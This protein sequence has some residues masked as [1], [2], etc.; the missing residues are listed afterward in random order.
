MK[1]TP[2]QLAGA[3]LSVALGAGALM[4]FSVADAAPGQIAGTVFEDYNQNGVKDANEPGLAG[5]T[6]TVTAAGGGN[7]QT[8]VSATDGTYALGALVGKQ[9]V[10]F[11]NPPT[12]LFPS[13][14]GSDNGSTVQFAVA[15]DTVNAA[16]AAPSDYCQANPSFIT[17]CMF[18]GDTALATG[19]SSLKTAPWGGGAAT[20]VNSLTDT[21]T[22]LG[23]AVQSPKKVYT[24]AFVKRHAGLGT[25]GA[26]GIYLTDPTTGVTQSFVDVSTLGIPVGSVPDTATRGLGAAGTPNIDAAV[27]PLVGKAGLGDID[28]SEDGQSLW[29][30]SLAGR[31]LHR[32]D[33]PANGSA[34]TT[35]NVLNAGVI[36]TTC[37]NGVARPFGLQPYR[38]KIYVGVVCTGEN[39]GSTADLSASVIVYDEAAATWSTKYGPFKID[40]T[41]GCSAGGPCNWQPWESAYSD[42]KFLFGP[43]WGGISYPQPMLSD[44]EFDT[45]GSLVLGFRDRS[46]DQFGFGQI[47]P[48]GT[49]NE[50]AR[51][52]GDI[53]RVC[54]VSGAL[55]LEG[56]VGCASNAV[57]GQGPGGGEFYPNEKNTQYGHQETSLGM[58]ELLKTQPSVAV[59]AYD[60]TTLYEGGVAFYDKTSGATTGVVSYYT[61]NGVDSSPATF[62]KTNGLGDLEALCDQAPIE[63]GNRLWV[64]NNGDGIQDAA[65]AG[66]G[67]VTVEL[68]KAGVLV[69]T[70]T[71]APDGSYYFNAANVTLGGATGIVANM[72]YEIRIPN[73]AGATKQAALAG[74]SLTVANAT[75]T[76]DEIDS[77]ATLSTTTPTTAI[78]PVPAVSIPLPGHNNHSF[79]AGYVPAYSVGN[80]VW[81]DNGAGAGGVANDGLQNGTE[82]GVAGVVVKLFASDASGNPTGVALSSQTTDANGFYRFDNLAPG[83]YVIVVDKNGSPTL[84][85]LNSSTGVAPATDVTDRNDNGIDTPLAAGSVLPGGIA[86]G[87]ITLGPSMPLGETD[88]PIGGAPD[89]ATDD[90]SNQT[91]DFGFA[92]TYSLGNRVWF[93]TN[94]NG[95]SDATEVGIANVKVTLLDASGNPVSGKTATTDA[96]G[97][98][99]FDGLAAG[100]YK[101]RID[102]MNFTTGGAL[103]GAASS[104]PTALNPNT[105]IDSDDNGLQPA[106][107]VAPQTSG[108][109]SGIVSLNATTA[110]PTNETDVASPNPAGEAANDRSNLTVDFGFFRTTVGNTVWYD[111]NNDGK[112]DASEPKLA[113]V[114]VEL[115]DATTGAVIGRATTDSNGLYEVTAAL[116]GSPLPVGTSVKVSIAAGQTVLAGLDAS[117]VVGTTD[118]TNHGSAMPNGDVMSVPFTLTPGVTTGGQTVDNAKGTTSNPTLDFGFNAPLASLGD[119]VW[120]DTNNNGIQDAGELGVPNVTV[121]LRDAAGV[122]LKT[123][124][125]DPNGN[126]KFI[127]LQPGTYVVRFVPSTLPAGATFTA[128]NQGTNDSVNSDADSN[129][130]ITKGYTIGKREYLPTVDAGIV[131]A[132]VPPVDPPFVVPP[133]VTPIVTLP[134]TTLP[135]TTASTTLPVTSVAATTVAPKTSTP[136]AP[137]ATTKG[138]IASTVWVDAN[139]NGTIDKGEKRVPNAEI[140]ITGPNGYTKTVVTDANGYYEV[141]D[142]EPGDYTVQLTGVGLSPDLEYLRGSVVTVTVLGNSVAKVEFP[143]AV[144]NSL[145]YT[146]S[147]NTMLFRIAMMLLA[148]GIGALSL[149]RRRRSN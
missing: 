91:I 25:L 73:S 15:G 88:L 100:D 48:T 58:T 77:D 20:S 131:L 17:A 126:Y 68:Y 120:A 107:A 71:T 110:E 59:S 30:V 98:Y 38:G 99:R 90:H 116:D 51:S 105:D 145:A 67:S 34:P 87:K 42:A 109:V 140:V 93:D 7:V 85:G 32:I 137:A 114:V 28:M 82:P 53:L 69:G 78:I 43:S 138:G 19:R 33:L 46:G 83:M 60:V 89:S 129:S 146:G 65:D 29:V 8:T 127:D 121:E 18:G 148:V 81:I 84:N 128:Q 132:V 36:P 94:N 13:A 5:V 26:G 76:A 75:T 70:T 118:S 23:V 79:D 142:L 37:A 134:S 147:N 1:R 27:W 10:E 31:S 11:T 44:I 113:G 72:D 112:I 136:A 80:R 106:T 139:K 123:T 144:G 57:N 103:F 22:V 104:T 56:G 117:A 141:G 35:S 2:L 119:T 4:P 92:P 111:T 3:L 49:G 95:L 133:A 86:S 47:R 97:Y 102:A 45:D 54:N 149:G 125:T 124:M 52:G 6:V 16:F 50:D 14:H 74:L 55:V 143:L 66:I 21:G 108:I 101:V 40:Y 130:G 115:R 62:G 24:A 63:I 122:V 9:R 39:A 41:K 64:D 135:V 12:G 96:N 61:S